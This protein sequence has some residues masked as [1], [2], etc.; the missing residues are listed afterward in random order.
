MATI[1]IRLASLIS[2]PLSQVVARFGFM[3][4]P[5][6]PQVLKLLADGHELEYEPMTAS[7][8]LSRETIIRNAKP[9]LNWLQH[10]IFTWMQ[11]NA[12]RPTDFFKIPP[13]R[14]VEMGTQVEL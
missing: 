8:F 5:S 14:V 6:V 11:R 9:A 7:F 2:A 13:N 10:T 1:S 4:D 3:E 12:S